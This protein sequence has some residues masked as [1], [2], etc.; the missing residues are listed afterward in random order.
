MKHLPLSL[1]KPLAAAML[2]VAAIAH[3]PASADGAADGPHF[4]TLGTGG[5]PVIQTKRSRP[6]NAVVVNGTVYLFD[7]GA[8]TLAQLAKADLAPGKVKAVFLSHHHI[9]HVA[10]LGPFLINRWLLYGDAAIP[11]KGPR[12]TRDMVTAIAA[13]SD[14][15]ALAPVTI[16]GKPRP[17]LSQTVATADLDDPMHKAKL[18]YQDENVRVLAVENDHYHFEPGS[19]A[20]RY[21]RS[22]AF[23]IEAGG[24]AIVYT[25]DTGWSERVVDLARGADLLVSEVIDIAGVEQAMRRNPAIPESALPALL[26][27]MEQ[28]HLTPRQVGEMAKAAGVGRVVLTHLVPGGDDETESSRYAADVAEVF[29]GPVIVANDLDRF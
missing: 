10:D 17:P 28:D 7:I 1:L 24:R 3:G 23:R 6:A 27:H 2:I 19:A 14:P 4:V 18:I 8:G 21:S 16:G 29:G 26:A 22:Y 20:D 15:I 13:M 5:G 9:D 25:G 11:V 12:G